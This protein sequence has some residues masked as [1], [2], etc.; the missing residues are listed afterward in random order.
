MGELAMKPEEMIRCCDW[1]RGEVVELSH[2]DESWS[3]C[4]DCG[5]TEAG[6]EEMTVSEFEELKEK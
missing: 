5:A 3:V 2:G 1:C 6:D 4:L